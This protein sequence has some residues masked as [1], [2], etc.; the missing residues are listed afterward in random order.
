MRRSCRAPS[1][2]GTTAAD[3]QLS[4]PYY[5]PG[6]MGLA[7]AM[8]TGL[9]AGTAPLRITTDRIPA[10]TVALRRGDQVHAANGPIGKVQGLI[11]LTAGAG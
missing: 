6:G 3:H 2:T 11:V 7:M 8:G 10:G 1:V 9:G 5:G 4:A